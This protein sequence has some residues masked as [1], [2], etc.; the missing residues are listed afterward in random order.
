[1]LKDALG[2]GAAVAEA[3]RLFKPSPAAPSHERRRFRVR[4]FL[5]LADPLGSR[6]RLWAV[7]F[8]L[9]VSLSGAAA[10]L[11][12]G[13]LTPVGVALGLI[14]A[15]DVA[16]LAAPARVR[17]RGL[18]FTPYFYGGA[19]LG[20]WTAAL[21]GLRPGPLA[22]HLILLC[23][24]ALP[25]VYLPPFA[26]GSRR[27]A[28]LQAGGV[29]AVF[30]LTAV[31]HALATTTGGGPF[32]GFLFLL[33]LLKTHGMVLALLAG[34]QAH[35]KALRA[36]AHGDPLTGLAN[37]RR[38]A[39]A[40]E[41][42]LDEARRT[43]LPCAV[44]VL[45]IDH[46]KRV[47]DRYGHETGDRV[48]REVAQRLSGGLRAGDALCRWGGEEFVVVAPATGALEAHRLGERLR[49]RV[50]DAPLR[51]GYRLTLSVGT[52]VAGEGDRPAALVARADAAL[53]RAKRAGRNRTVAA[54]PLR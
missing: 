5:P 29:L 51:G 3:V 2:E 23:A 37:R 40:L 4:A 44:L 12:G 16:L 28:L 32:D 39:H 52:A 53:Y 49:R 22:E 24:L 19:L 43:G 41:G 13:G 26:G 31:P 47:N 46:F 9:V 48:L 10:E 25:V 14:A 8:T 54:E 30:G 7:W 1:M 11:I 21:Y 15:F 35:L 45:D 6:V 18:Q 17:G 20:G 42:F 38:A 36:A 34:A 27:R 33:I 50:A